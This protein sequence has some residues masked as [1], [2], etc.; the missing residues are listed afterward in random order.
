MG[1]HQFGSF[2][3]GII[4]L[5]INTTGEFVTERRQIS[6]CGTI[7][8]ESQS[9]SEHGFHLNQNSFH[10]RLTASSSKS[11]QRVQTSS[12]GK[13]GQPTAAMIE[14]SL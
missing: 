12:T 4:D 7:G 2:T 10:S 8:L 13:G 3:Q 5:L 9:R 6:I 1:D 14:K 11:L